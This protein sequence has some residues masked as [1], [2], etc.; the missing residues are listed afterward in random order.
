MRF[1]KWTWGGNR[2]LDGI[3]IPTCARTVLKA[4]RGQ[5]RTCPYI[6]TTTTTVLWPLF[7]DHPGEP[8][9]EENFW[10]LWSKGRLMEA[11]TPAIQPGAT[12]S[13]LTSAHL[14]HPLVFYRLDALPATQP[15]VSKH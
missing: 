8:V 7:R 9:P 13:G 11:D 2:V 1:G 10:T 12:P 5:P 14:Q 4:E 15:T 3:Q 6:C